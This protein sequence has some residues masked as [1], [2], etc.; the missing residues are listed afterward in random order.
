VKPKSCIISATDWM[1]KRQAQ[2]HH[3][4]SIVVE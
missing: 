1:A 3:P 2:R 4:G